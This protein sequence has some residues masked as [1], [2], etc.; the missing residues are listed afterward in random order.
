MMNTKRTHRIILSL[1]VLLFA[2]PWILP[3][4][5]LVNIAVLIGIYSLMA[6]GLNLLIGYAG[7]ISLGHAAFYGLGAYTA[8]V[9]AIRFQM[10]TFLAMLAAMILVGVIA[11]LIGRPTLKLKGHYLA[12][13]TLGFG[14]VVQIILEE[15][16]DLTGGTQGLSNIPKL[17]IFGFEFQNDFEIYFLVWGLVIL[18]QLMVVYLIQGKI[19][20]A[21]LAIHTNETAAESLGIHTA[22]LKLSAFVISAVLAGMAGAFYAFSISY[23]SPEPFGYNFSVMLVTMVIVGG[24]GSLW[25]PLV[26]TVI[27]GV[28]PELLRGFKNFDTVFYGLL[29]MLIIIFLPG[30]ITSVFGKIKFGSQKEKSKGGDVI[31]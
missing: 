10:N 23:I 3:N 8:S 28:I 21:F 18:I 29:L 17:N 25:G 13:A 27:M 26:G 5:Y 6:I 12:M 31:G 30:G 20:R 22:S 1:G 16:V 24:S 4:R 11:W 2:V 19:G 15:L 7:Q 14:V 9:L